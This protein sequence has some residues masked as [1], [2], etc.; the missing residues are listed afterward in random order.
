MASSSPQRD[1]RP[2]VLI[3][4]AAGSVG[5]SLSGALA[6]DYRVVGM[7]VSVP[8]DG[9]DW[10]EIDLTSD[11]SVAG[12]FAKFRERFGGRIA[13]VVHLAAYFDFS[14]EYRPLYD[15]VNVD[16]TR[17][18]LRALRALD[19]EQ[20]VYSG[21]MLVHEATTP[22]SRIDEDAP[23]RPRWAY[24][25]SKAAAERAI[26]EERGDIPCVLLHLAGLY[27]DATAV[28]TLSQQIARI[29]ERD[30][31]GFL[32][33]GDKDAG[34]SMIHRE[35]MIDAFRR[36]IDRRGELPPE[37]TVLVGEPDAI[38]YAELQDL[39][40]GL[41]HGEDWATIGV[42]PPLAKAGAWLQEKAEPLVP[43]AID[44]GK[45]PFI[46]PFMIE[47]AS[48][49][50]ALDIRRARELLGWEPRH[51]IRDTLP[52]L[53]AA[54][55]RDPP[56][57]YEA[58]G[59]TM[60]PWLEAAA[61]KVE[62]PEAL[63]GQAE[64]TF[65]DAHRRNLWGPFL[66]AALGV[67]LLASPPTFGDVAGALALSDRVSGAALLVL[68]L[69]TT[70]WRLAPLRWA[71]AAVGLWVM[72]APLVFWTGSAAAYLNGTLVGAL[73]TGLAAALPPIPGISPVASRTGPVIPP[74]W[75][76]SPSDWIQ[77]LP[78]I[79]L[80]LLGLIVSRYM[81]AYQLGHAD[82]VWEPFFDVAGPK[83]GTE[84]IV[85]SSVSEA[86]PVPDAGLGALVYVLEIV[87]G[88]VGSRQRW[89][90]MPWV[91]VAFGI[92]IVPLG[93]V[94]I[95]FIIIQPIV[96][97]TWCTLCLI[98]AAAMLLQI[99]YSLD[100]LIA[101]G[102][103]LRRRRRA[104]RSLLQVFFTGDTDE[105]DAATERSA[106]EAGEFDKGPLQVLRETLGGNVAP[107][108]NLLACAA[109]G[110]WLMC[111]RLTV[112]AEGTMAD[113]D[114]LIGALAITAAVIAFAEVAR[115]V[116]LFNVLLGAALLVVPFVADAGPASLWSSLVCGVALIALSLPRGP[117]RLRYG[118][119]NRLLV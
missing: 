98:G 99:P 62:R 10:I 20:F 48:D 105:G 58:N 24:P 83:N 102:Q 27:D 95:T 45:A 70:S 47:I 84:A 78:I 112:G 4:G 63:R 91:V 100:E 80:A 119:W 50:Y 51:S 67:W 19:V 116:R 66:I 6:G 23:I 106:A 25:Q 77:R 81:A 103:F 82:G 33:A 11:D 43:D 34:Q 61:A 52:E 30:L 109:I 42:P 53:V 56:A 88:L 74:G 108:W 17:R 86:W 57:W 21:T 64:A 22:G 38:G 107:R 37:L 89:R 40:G 71:S 96:I 31:Q 94:S 113:A 41:V 36:A 75:D 101:T 65:R 13:S 87:T 1:E 69:L 97:G 114:H 16:G 90:T 18:L 68:G 35:D 2:I 15:E 111:T 85:T 32:Y 8:D 117:V 29:Y 55:K 14:G 46:R 7:D 72:F 115:P 110:V 73:V 49:H 44:K 9:G 28:P 39:I 104:G 118:D 5:N 59:I 26:A 79:A 93:V 76:Y 92:L 54:L 60:P 12:A 3:T